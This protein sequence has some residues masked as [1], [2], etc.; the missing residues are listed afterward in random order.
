MTA[1]VSSQVRNAL[2]QVGALGALSEEELEKLAPFGSLQ[3][4]A[5]GQTLLR[6]GD[7][8][9]T[10]YFVIDGKFAVFAGPGQARIGEIGRG[11]PVGEVAFFRGGARTADV[12][13]IRQA[14]V[15]SF[16]RSQL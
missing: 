14:L 3:A 9:D 6:K 5:R 1:S 13:A 10:L 4:I 11:E 16:H 12:V 15:L 2:T 8:A 7:I